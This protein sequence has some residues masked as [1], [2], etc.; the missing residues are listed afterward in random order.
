[1]TARLWRSR[2]RRAS[3]VAFAVVDFALIETVAVGDLSVPGGGIST[4]IYILNLPSSLFVPVWG[5]FTVAVADVLGMPDNWNLSW[6]P[7]VMAALIQALLV[8]FLA[9]GIGRRCRGR[10]AA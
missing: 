4:A 5:W 9:R 2:L 10:R 1:M 8:L 6:V 7:A 3:Y